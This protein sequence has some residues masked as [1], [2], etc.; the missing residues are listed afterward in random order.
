MKTRLAHALS[1]DELCKYNFVD[2]INGFSI[3]EYIFD[4]NKEPLLSF[5]HE[6]DEYEFIIPLKT[7]SL[8]RYE[9]ANY[10]GEVGYCYPVNPHINHGIEFD[11]YQ[12]N[13]I[14]IAVSKEIVETLKK[15]CGFEGKFF[16][17]KFFV[18]KELSLSIKKFQELSRKKHRDIGIL[19]TLSKQI[20]ILL[21]TNGLSLGVDKRKPEKIYAK[22]IRQII[23]YMFENYK[24]PEL[25]IESLSKLSGYSSAYFSRAFK[26]YMNESPI[27]HLNKLR[28]SEARVLFLNKNLSLYQIARM[29]G[30]KNTSTFT[31]AFKKNVGMKPKKYRDKYY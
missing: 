24:D 5:Q 23:T 8:L 19:E 3:A 11:L 31:E 7:I 30:Y 14:S 27:V 2:E 28:L 21:I 1:E 22:N 15:K 13:V 25:T 9:K 6:H 16:Y 20:I 18:E 26:A 10:I 4:K 17:S 29:V 12:S